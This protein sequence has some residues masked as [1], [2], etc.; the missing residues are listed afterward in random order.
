MNGSDCMAAADAAFLHFERPNERLHIG[1][2]AE[3]GGRLHVDDVVEIVEKRLDSTPRFRQRPV[4]R[5]LDLGSPTWEEDPDFDVHRHVRWVGVPEPSGARE[6]EDVV[7]L[8]LSAPLD[9]AHPLWDVTLLEGFRARTTALLCRAHHCMCDGASGVGA[10]EALLVDHVAHGAETTGDEHGAAQ[11]ADWPRKRRL[12]RP[13]VGAGRDATGAAGFR[14]W[15]GTRDLAGAAGLLG[16][17]LL[18]AP[19]RLEFN[20][21]LQE[22]RRIVWTTFPLAVVRSLALE[23]PG[24]TANDV[25]LTV[26]AGALRHYVGDG[27]PASAPEAIRVVVPVSVRPRDDR[28]PGNL[29]SA[30]FPDLPIS[31]PDPIARLRAVAGETRRLKK[32]GQARATALLLGAGSALPTPLQILCGRLRPETLVCN[33]LCTHVHGPSSPR[34]VLGHRVIGLH[35]IAPLFQEMGLAFAIMRYADQVSLCA[36]LDPHL[37]PDPGRVRASLEQSY[38]EMIA[39]RTNGSGREHAATLD[40]A[41]A[42]GNGNGSAEEPD[43]SPALHGHQGVE[44]VT[45]AR[46]D[47]PI[48]M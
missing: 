9:P 10:L 41:T 44:L 22:R 37:V 24:S 8:L 32:G 3:I 20:H 42:S 14:G 25:M 27:E 26:I 17:L 45:T 19:A 43:G 5:S 36:V 30:I 2:L 39:A 34:F 46:Q 21:R 16:T 18:D 6:M 1:C 13:S 12:A 4:R 11:G 29:V 33:T 15:P 7:E 28:T 48:P 31:I 38:T 35:A 40:V 47:W 23:A